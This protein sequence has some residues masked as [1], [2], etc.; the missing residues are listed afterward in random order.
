MPE[1]EEGMEFGDDPNE[2]HAAGDGVKMTLPPRGRPLKEML[3]ERNAR[4]LQ[5]SSATTPRSGKPTTPP[6][7]TMSSDG[8]RKDKTRSEGPPAST[9]KK[10]KQADSTVV[11]GVRQRDGKRTAH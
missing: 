5:T 6:D 1:V 2:T 3:A 9:V 7:V 10:R 4:A 11:R 8:T